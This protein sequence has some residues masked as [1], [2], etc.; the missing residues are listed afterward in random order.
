MAKIT[1]SKD[2]LMWL[3][4]AKGDEGRQC[5]PIR[6]RTRLMKM[7]FLFKKEIRRKFNMGK[8]ISKD[9]LPDFEAYDFGPFSAQ[10]FTDLEFLVELGF[11]HVKSAEGVD[12]LPEESL[13]YK[14]WKAGSESESDLGGPEYEEDFS[15]T[16]LGKEFVK[17]GKVGKLS[18][19]QEVVLN[20]FKAR[21]TAA[22][23]RSLLRYVYTNYPKTITESKIRD[24]ILSEKPS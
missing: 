15:L 2:L 7:V 6:G 5:Q 17:D 11:V 10:L 16:S 13:E 21:C 19:D 24:E 1:N 20:E 9:A 4:Y 23:L 12:L 22:S 8:V 18:K 3:L 14:Y